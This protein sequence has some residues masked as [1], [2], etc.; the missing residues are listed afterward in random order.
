MDPRVS[1]SMIIFQG[2]TMETMVPTNPQIIQSFFLKKQLIS[3]R[4]ELRG[5]MPSLAVPLHSHIWMNMHSQ[6]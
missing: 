5:H 4:N 1:D 2:E 6:K 3:Q